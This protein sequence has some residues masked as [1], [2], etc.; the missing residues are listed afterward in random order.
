M[1]MIS[2]HKDDPETLPQVVEYLDVYGIDMRTLS[3]G[4]VVV[5]W[6]DDEKADEI[7]SASLKELPEFLTDED[8]GIRLLAVHR[9]EELNKSIYCSY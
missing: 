9:L 2:R 5:Y 4:I 3:N 8:Y 1:E 6:C 7:L